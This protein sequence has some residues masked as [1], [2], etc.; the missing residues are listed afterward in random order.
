MDK[1]KLRQATIENLKQ[2]TIEEKQKTEGSLIHQLVQSELWQQANTIGVTMSQGFEWD[3][4]EIIEQA[5]KQNKIVCV[6]KC[7]P[8][9]KKLTFYQLDTY[10]QLE[11]VYYNLL[12]PIPV[13]EKQMD[14]RTIDLLIVPGILFDRMGYRIGFGGG[15]YDRFLVDFPNKTVSLL[16]TIQLVDKVPSDSFDIP[17]QHL[18]T[19]K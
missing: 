18:I 12:E 14:K 16:S 13:R 6:P 9:Q 8:Q 1:R 15:Y 17:V 19:N 10:D 4:K 2:L 7:E 11:T 3:T 5:W